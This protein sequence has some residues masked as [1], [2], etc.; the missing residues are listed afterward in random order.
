MK[1]LMKI[2]NLSIPIPHSIELKKLIE[3][4][5]YKAGLREQNDELKFNI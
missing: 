2:F 3:S 4:Y 1:V 5:F